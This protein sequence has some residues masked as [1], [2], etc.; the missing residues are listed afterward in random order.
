VPHYDALF[1]WAFAFGAFAIIVTY[2][3][4]CLGAPRALAG[5]PR[6]W[7]VLLA[8]VIGVPVSAGALFTGI[9]RVPAP[10]AW[11]PWAALG[12]L[13]AALLAGLLIPAA[14]VRTGAQGPSG[15]QGSPGS[16]QVRPVGPG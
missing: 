15:P 2:L 11:A 12:V 16:D 1:R 9:Y 6:R 7:A 10:V 13:G 4:L 3:L 8:T 14:P 5:H